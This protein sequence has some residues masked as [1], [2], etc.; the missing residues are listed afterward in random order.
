LAAVYGARIENG[1]ARV[2]VR[3]WVLV[4][5]LAAA[6]AIAEPV[7]PW[8]VGVTE[9]DQA[10]AEE[11]FARGNVSVEQGLFSDA[12][13]LYRK[14]LVIWD[15]PAIRYNLAVALINLEREIDADEQLEHALRFGAGALEP[16]VYKE[17]LSYQRL[18]HAHIVHL[19]ID[20][21]DAD[22]QV[23]LDGKRLAVACPGTTRLRILPGGHRLIAE[24]PSSLTRTIDLA[25]AGGDEAHVHID[26]MTIDEATI[27]HRRWAR[28]KPWLVVGA[29]GLAGLIGAAIDLQA[30]ATFRSYDRAVATLCPGPTPCQSLPAVVSDAAVEGRHERD[31]AFAGFAVGGAALVTGAV[32]VWFN[33]SIAER[34]GYEHAPIVTAS[35]GRDAWGLAMHVAF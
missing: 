13:D 9:A 25:P 15:H 24:A 12:V 3:W 14:A 20:C 27:H 34:I 8:A 11:L 29:G 2:V 30:A 1:Y 21:V 16:E 7:R 31:A 23:T 10:R 18:L 26:L 6:P 28:W 35:L 4:V 17:A 19:V 32:L 22:T 5:V 33:R